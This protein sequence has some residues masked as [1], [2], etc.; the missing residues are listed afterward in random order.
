MQFVRASL[1]M[2]L[3]MLCVLLL[4]AGCQ[5]APEHENSAAARRGEINPTEGGAVSSAPIDT[6]S[7]PPAVVAKKPTTFPIKNDVDWSPLQLEH[8]T[9]AL[10][11]VLDYQRND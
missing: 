10:S 9:V 11:C 4:A 2:R 1:A 3:S 7:Q 8:G 6:E 5:R